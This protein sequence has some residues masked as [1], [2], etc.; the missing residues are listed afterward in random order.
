MD[1]FFKP[2][3]KGAR[4]RIIEDRRERLNALGEEFKEC[5]DVL[6]ALGDLTRQLIVLT[7]IEAGCHPGVRVGDITRK[8]HL[9]RPAVSHHLKVLK[10]AGILDV[11]RQGTMNFYSLNPAQS[12][13]LKLKTLVAHVEEIIKVYK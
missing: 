1:Y 3:R 10:D 11:T 13:L 8:T 4:S 5:Q 2:L 12:D 6:F 7:L 9:S